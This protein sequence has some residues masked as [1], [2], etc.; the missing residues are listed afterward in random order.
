M[1]DDFPIFLLSIGVFV[2]YLLVSAMTEMGT[3][4]PGLKKTQQQSMKP[5]RDQNPNHGTDDR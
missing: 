4:W 3:V 1:P 5:E 2:L